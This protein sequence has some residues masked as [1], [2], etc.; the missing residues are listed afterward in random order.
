VFYLF[1]Y[2]FPEACIHNS[3]QLTQYWGRMWLAL[4]FLDA[5]FFRSYNVR[6]TILLLHCD[7]EAK[8]FLE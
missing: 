6:L 5:L 8:E 7:F 4:P 2:K 1:N 3:E